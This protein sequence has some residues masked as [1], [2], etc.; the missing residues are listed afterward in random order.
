MLDDFFPA[1]VERVGTAFEEQHA[2]DVFLEF[3]GVHLAA[4]NVGGGEQVPLKLR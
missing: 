2:E 1:L 4:Q 3:G